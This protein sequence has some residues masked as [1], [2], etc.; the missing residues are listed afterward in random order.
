MHTRDFCLCKL[1]KFCLVVR[2]LMGGMT[3]S[4]RMVRMSLVILRMWN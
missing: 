1:R 4:M 3:L 2:V